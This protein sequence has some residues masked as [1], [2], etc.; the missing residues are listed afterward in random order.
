V[1]YRQ[2]L[3]EAQLFRPQITNNKSQTLK[4][5]FEEPQKFVAEGQSAVFYVPSEA[6][7]KDGSNYQMIGGGIIA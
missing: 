7:A 1:R 4:L 5:V 2:Q 6:S 3:C